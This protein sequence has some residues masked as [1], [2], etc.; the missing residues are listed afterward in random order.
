MHKCTCRCADTLM[1][2]L[3][4]MQPQTMCQWDSDGL[5]DHRGLLQHCF[6]ADRSSAAPVVSTSNHQEASVCPTMKGT[7]SSCDSSQLRR[8]EVGNGMLLHAAGPHR[9]TLQSHARAAEGNRSCIRSTLLPVDQSNLSY[10]AMQE[11]FDDYAAPKSGHVAGRSQQRVAD[12]ELTAALQPD[13][14]SN[15]PGNCNGLSQGNR[16]CGFVFD[17]LRASYKPGLQHTLG[18][19][20]YSFR[21]AWMDPAA[22]SN[23]CHRRFHRS[24]R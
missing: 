4:S 10:K 18:G 19:A 14:G 20:D 16:V 5:Y 21:A 9:S 2:S 17:D 12:P 13:V 3:R 6:Q 7:H 11:L 24:R 22:Q 23:A 1:S 15:E 8:A